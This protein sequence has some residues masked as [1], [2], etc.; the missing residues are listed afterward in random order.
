MSE[1]KKSHPKHDVV[2]NKLHYGTKRYAGS[3]PYYSKISC[4]TTNPPVLNSSSPIGPVTFQLPGLNVYHRS[5]DYVQMDLTF[6][7]Q[8]SSYNFT[9]GH[10]GSMLSSVI[11][12]SV[13][14]NI[15]LLNLTN[16]GVFCEG[17]GTVCTS[18]PELRSK[19]IPP[20]GN[21]MTGSVG[22]FSESS[23]ADA[24]TQTIEELSRSN[25]ATNYTPVMF[26]ATGPVGTFT[27]TNSVDIGSAYDG[28]TIVYRQSMT[29]TGA[30]CYVSVRLPVSMFKCTYGSW[31]R[32]TWMRDELQQVDLQF[33]AV[34][35]WTWYGTSLT[36]PSSGASAS[37]AVPT[38]S[39]LFYYACIESDADT[40][41]TVKNMILN[42]GLE[43]NL[44]IILN[45]KVT[46][47]NSATHSVPLTLTQGTADR[48]LAVWDVPINNTE[49][50]YTCKS[51]TITQFGNYTT[52]TNGFN[53]DTQNSISY[54]ADNEFYL[55][56]KNNLVGSILDN[57]I[58]F[59]NRYVL[60]TNYTDIPLVQLAKDP[61]IEAGEPLTGQWVWNYTMNTNNSVSLSLNH[62][63]FYLVQRRLRVD[64]YGVRFIQ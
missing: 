18:Y 33:D 63:I 5:K 64:R 28:A 4:I 53:N 58:A 11:F 52:T 34:N 19:P 40:A 23:L 26:N 9:A 25:T 13:G 17:V 48:V 62:Y 47:T 15:Q 21:G 1:V 44:P 49:T 36:N 31:D 61:T 7:G 38:I 3:K 29:G 54:V 30:N 56:Q 41:N 2:N 32:A 39:N 10:L 57:N 60:T 51:H 12:T 8:A 37:T 14:S 43:F 35:R 16:A 6:P 24:Q 27:P 46:I 22:A 55:F 59:A 20:N 45:N 42:E 50:S